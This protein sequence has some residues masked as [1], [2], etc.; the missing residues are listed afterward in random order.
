MNELKR[1][2][3]DEQGLTMVELLA[4]IVILAIIAGIGMVAIGNV[5]QNSREDAAVSSVQQAYEAGEMYNS[6]E[7]PESN[8]SLQQVIDA[9][10]LKQGDTW[11]SDKLGAVVF[12]IDSNGSIKMQVVADSLNA[13]KKKS[14]TAKEVDA[15]NVSKLKRDMFGFQ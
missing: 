10:Y 11:A 14:K 7:Q 8:F 12:E 6:T 9:K 15:G 5:L 2:W 3:K 4:T 1:V 13:G